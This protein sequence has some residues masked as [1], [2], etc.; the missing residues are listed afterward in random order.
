MRQT[1]KTAMTKA[2]VFPGQGSQYPG[3]AKDLYDSL[4]EARERFEAANEILGFRITD[5]MFGGSSDDLKATNV[6]QPA[7]FLHS[8]ILAESLDDF[9]PDMVAGHSLGEFSALAAAGAISFEDALRLVAIRAREMQKCCEKVPGGM[10]AVIGMDNAAV[11]KLCLDTPGIVVPANYNCDGQVVI[12]GEKEAIAAACGAAKAAG[13]KR[14]LPLAVGGAFHSPL[15]EPAR[16]ELGKAIEATKIQ[17]PCCPVYQNVTARPETDP[18]AIKANLLAQLTSPVRWTQT[19][20][21][22]LVDG[23]DWFCEIGP[24]TVLQGLVKRISGGMAETCGVSG[25]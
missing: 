15:M 19:I 13:A 1:K 20:G 17:E 8:V 12:S 11:E 7:I 3:M 2:Y 21:N 25:L 23:A 16:L 14:A 4:P 5:I 10:A 9:R 6:T 24:G 18:E 22:M